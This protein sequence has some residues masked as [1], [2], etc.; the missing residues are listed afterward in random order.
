MLL[1]EHMPIITSMDATPLLERRNRELLCISGQMLI[2]HWIV[3]LIGSASM[4]VLLAG[5]A[6]TQPPRVVSAMFT[7]AR[8]T[9]MQLATRYPI[10]S[11]SL[12]VLTPAAGR[13][14]IPSV[15]KPE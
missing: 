6:H 3:G 8:G 5:K 12:R 15:S 9:A 10:D 2:N 13:N 4:R 14:Q 11:C 1:I 7:G